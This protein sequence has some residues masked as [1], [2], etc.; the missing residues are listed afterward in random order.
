MRFKCIIGF[1]STGSPNNHAGGDKSTFWSAFN[2]NL[3]TT[4]YW[5][6]L[7]RLGKQVGVKMHIDSNPLFPHTEI[8]SELCKKFTG[9]FNSNI[10]TYVLT[11]QTL[12][13]IFIYN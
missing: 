6:R 1:L 5:E 12:I 4:K 10:L 13:G 3:K 7:G 11:V 8:V 9:E 2:S